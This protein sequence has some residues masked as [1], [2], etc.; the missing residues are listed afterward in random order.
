MVFPHEH[1]LI[2]FLGHFGGAT[3][4]GLDTWSVGL[5]MGFGNIAPL[6]DEAKLQTLVNACQDAGQNF[7]TATNVGTGTSCYFD[8]V[9][10]AQV[11]VTGKYVPATQLTVMSPVEPT[12]GVGGGTMPW[13]AALVISLRTEAPRGYASNGRMYWPAPGMACDPATGRISNGNVTSRVNAAKAFIN[14]LNTAADAY[15][16]GMRVVVGSAVGGGALRHV[17][18]VRSDGRVD[19]IERRENNQVSSWVTA[20]IP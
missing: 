18:A 13:T 15:S 8:Q 9:T 2:R 4:P 19:G 10:G 3:P 14:A 1:L 11:G 7:H 16:M 5:R 12:A 17:T 6:Y 20:T